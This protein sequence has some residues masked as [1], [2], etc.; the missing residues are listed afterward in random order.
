MSLFMYAKANYGS[1]LRAAARYHANEAFRL[2]KYENYGIKKCMSLKNACH[3][4]LRI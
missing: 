4:Q 2:N 1:D 3:L